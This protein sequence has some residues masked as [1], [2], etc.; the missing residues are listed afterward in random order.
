MIGLIAKRELQAALRTPAAWLLFGAVQFVC[1]WQFLA[2]VE[3]YQRNQAR[4]RTLQDAPGLTDLVVAP[5]FAAIAFVML[6]FVPL[7]TMR[8]LCEERANGEWL[9]LRAAPV[10]IAD[11]VLGKFLGCVALTLVPLACAALMPLSLYAG[12]SIDAGQY[13]SGA[14]GL[15]LVTVLFIAV[16]LAISALT[17]HPPVAAGGAILALLMLWLVDWQR[18]DPEAG[19]VLPY[20]SAARHFER[21]LRGILDTTDIA[22]FLLATVLFLLLTGWRLAVARGV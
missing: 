7:L 17:V 13:L 10:K 6:L 1:A 11:I 16:G 21:L 2:Q 5:A 12:G 4:L 18:A 20:L 19:S 3:L 9:V 14:L 8:A 15:A 22:Y